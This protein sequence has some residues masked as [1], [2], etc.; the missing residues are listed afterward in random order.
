MDQLDQHNASPADNAARIWTNASASLRASGLLTPREL[1]CVDDI[2]PVSVF[3]SMIVLNASNETTR[4][5]V[6]QK[7]EVM[8]ALQA[9][10]GGIPLTPLIK[11]V[12]PR[13]SL[14]QRN[15]MRKSPTQA[16]AQSS[17]GGQ[18]LPNQ[19]INS[20][21]VQP[22]SAQVQQFSTPAQQFGTQV[23]DAGNIQPTN[24][25]PSSGVTQYAD[26]GVGQ[27]S[28]QAQSFNT[29]QQPQQFNAQQFA[30]PN[31]SYTVGSAQP[32]Q[33]AA[34][35]QP[36]HAEQPIHWQ[37]SSAATTPST[38]GAY[39][40]PSGNTNPHFVQ[41]RFDDTLPLSGND[42][43]SLSP[44]EL[45]R[46]KNKTTRDKLTHLDV[47]ATFATFVPGD[48]NRFAHSAA[49]A[50]AESP[51]RTFN[52][53]C[54]YGGSGLGKTHL[55]NAIGNYAL[56]EDPTLKVRYVNSEEFINDF[57][58]SLQGSAQTG[59]IITEFHRRY[60]E[61]D[62][63]LIDDIQF[64]GGKGETLQQ[65]F[66][67]FN[68]LH[69]ANKQ[70]VIASDVAPKNLKGFEERLITRFESGLSVDVLPPDLE[71]RIAILRMKAQISG[72]DIPEDAL[73]F[74]A[75][76]V[77]DNVR[78]LEGALTRVTAMASLN[79]QVI[80]RSLVQQ[81][82]QDFFTAEVEIRPT[83]IINIVATYFS[84]SFD[85]IVGP[86]RAKN[87]VFPR[88]VAM[89]LTRELTSQSLH[90][91]GLIFGGRDHST[92]MHACKKIQTAMSQE[93]EVYNYVT[94]LTNKIK[95][96]PTANH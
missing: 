33:S 59:G 4:S 37:G 62:V 89:Y 11:I 3:D 5:T 92:V 19:S 39:T 49:L 27:P 43:S 75:E 88:Q 8:E 40:Q 29:Q 52:P 6:E 78:E 10:N 22:Q 24:M 87:V 21:P 38:A 77:T 74:I 46:G 51:G 2:S 12:P 81:T 65:F 36:L 85:E 80:T 14:A 66:H 16:P 96:Q 35:A 17:Q 47:N 83:D 42:D 70:I 58:E 63:L 31:T 57:I 45:N 25:Q 30:Q 90:D 32:S 13:P 61:V 48:S 69:S 53:L 73:D 93:R 84:V 15:A 72:L 18:Q 26:S 23:Q 34:P 7:H 79:D 86:W 64:L 76:Q 41:Q 55:L 9:A 1:A 71:T 60:R 50:V 67:T 28:S 44:L 56:K 91:I 94:E 68:A 54:I 95:R 82:L 20:Q